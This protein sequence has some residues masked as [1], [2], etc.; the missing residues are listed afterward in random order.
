MSLLEIKNL[1]V[2]NLRT[3]QQIIHDLSFSLH[4]NRCLCIVG[5]S[6]SG[7]SMTAKAILG[8]T[9]PWLQVNGEVLFKGMNL[10][11]QS[12]ATMRKVR[13]QKICMILQD[14]MTAFDPLS[15]IGKQ[16]IETLRENLVMN[17]T[18]AKELAI[19]ALQSVQIYEPE[20]VLKKYPHQLS[21]GMLQRVM[22]SIVMVIKPDII[23][24]DEPTTALDSINQREVVEQFKKLLAVNHVSMIFISHDLSVVQYLADDVLVMKDGKCVELGEASKILSTPSHSFTKFLIDTRVGLS[25]SFQQSMSGGEAIVLES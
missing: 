13:G 5:E 4:E 20:Q 19:T 21:G 23:I 16:M 6:G 24:A 12:N 8:L 9:S 25:Q 2:N 10:I 22:I 15:T 3:G 17:K 7:K 14:A 11:E 18:E 1:S